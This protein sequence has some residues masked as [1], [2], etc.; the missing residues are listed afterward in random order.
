MIFSEARL[1][2]AVHGYGEGG[3]AREV[4]FGCLHLHERADGTVA[5]V[6]HDLRDGKIDEH[7][8]WRVVGAEVLAPPG[9][10]S[11]LPSYRTN[12]MGRT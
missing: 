1:R 4:I 11:I 12:L 6:C 2:L 8:L 10:S 5:A 9:D 7:L 3:D